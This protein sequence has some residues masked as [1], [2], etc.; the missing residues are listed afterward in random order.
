MRLLLFPQIHPILDIRSSFIEKDVSNQPYRT[1]P[2]FPDSIE[3]LGETISFSGLSTQGYTRR[4]VEFVPFI[5]IDER[6]DG[7]YGARDYQLKYGEAWEEMTEGWRDIVN[8]RNRMSM[9]TSQGKIE[10]EYNYMFGGRRT[11]EKYSGSTLVGRDVME[12]LF[13]L[14]SDTDPLMNFKY[15]HKD[16]SFWILPDD[17]DKRDFN[18]VILTAE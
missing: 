5:G 13:C 12:R 2:E 4:N 7:P 18:N 11:L 3:L 6:Y 14:S 8:K 10:F 1:V 15:D 9:G 16:I 17:L